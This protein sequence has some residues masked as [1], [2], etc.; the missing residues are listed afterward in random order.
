MARLPRAEDQPLLTVDEV[1]AIG[2][3]RRGR[4]AVYEAIRRGEVPSLR[5][6]RTLFVPTGKLRALLGLEDDDG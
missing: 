2:V 4:S 6:G 3:L 5:I 1:I